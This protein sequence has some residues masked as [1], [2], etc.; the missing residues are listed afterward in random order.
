[1]LHTTYN[2]LV[3]LFSRLYFEVEVKFRVNV[4]HCHML[5]LFLTERACSCV[6]REGG[7]NGN[8]LQFYLIRRKALWQYD[9]RTQ[10][11]FIVHFI[12]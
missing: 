9:T 7:E 12:S 10:Q 4:I 5:K 6:K 3:L 2:F 1:M 8:V 11:P